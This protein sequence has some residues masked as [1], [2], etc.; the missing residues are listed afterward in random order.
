MIF[1]KD[2]HRQQERFLFIYFNL[3]I[4]LLVTLA[5]AQTIR[6]WTVGWLMYYEFEKLWKEV[7][8]AC[9]KV[10][11]SICMKGLRK[12]TETLGQG[13]CYPSRDSN[14]T[15]LECKSE[16]LLSE[17]TCSVG[18]ILRSFWTLKC[19]FWMPLIGAYL[20]MVV[21]LFVCVN[22]R[23]YHTVNRG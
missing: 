17:P 7:F 8:M 20:Y 19:T 15:P 23:S 2:I 5:V 16:A 22:D 13:S 21:Q 14:W 3:F 10:L 6:Y 1:F 11:S 4:Y 12:P 9:F 18:D